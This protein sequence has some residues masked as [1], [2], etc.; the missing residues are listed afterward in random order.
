MF[1][2]NEDGT[3][4]V[5]EN[6]SKAVDTWLVGTS[7]NYIGTVIEEQTKIVFKP[8]PKLTITVEDN[9]WVTLETEFVRN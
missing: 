6:I 8:N 7:G 5:Q 3:I 4:T 1:R 2:Y 9:S